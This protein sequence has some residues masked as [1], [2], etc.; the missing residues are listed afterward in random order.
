MTN[1]DNAT[2]R[3]TNANNISPHTA[4]EV[5]VITTT[6]IIKLLTPGEPFLSTICSLNK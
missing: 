4:T 2:M 6:N 1:A 3:N 5:T